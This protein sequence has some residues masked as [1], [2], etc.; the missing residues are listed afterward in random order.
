[1]GVRVGYQVRVCIVRAPDGEQE[2][3]LERFLNAPKVIG[4]LIATGNTKYL[5]IFQCLKREIKEF[6]QREEDL[7]LALRIA[8][9]D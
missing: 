3:T 7:A 2:I 4:T 1:M 9:N 6:Q 8:K 5:P